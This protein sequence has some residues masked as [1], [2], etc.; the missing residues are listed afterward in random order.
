MI[1]RFLWAPLALALAMLPAFGSASTNE[2]KIGFQPYTAYAPVLVAKEKGYVEKA[3]QAAGAGNVT[4]KWVQFLT[5]PQTN[6]AL[7]SGDIDMIAGEGDMP[8]MLAKASGLDI[9]VVGLVCPAASEEALVV[10]SDSPVHSVKEL[11]GLKVA[12]VHGG[13]AYA[14]LVLALKQAGLSVD[15]VQLVNLA[16]GEM[17]VALEN[18][19]VDA[20]T[21]FEPLLTRG[22]AGGNVRVLRDGVGLTSNL[23]LFAVSSAFAK[24]NP[25]VLKAILKAVRQGADDLRAHPKEWATNLAPVIGL[26]PSENAHAMLHHD[27][28]PN[29]TAANIAEMKSDLQFMVDN[30]FAR[31]SFDVNSFVDMSYQP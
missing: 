3:L 27:W 12:S 2:V 14:F 21:L 11:K 6:Q 8:L 23:Q 28:N 31:T 26:T 5:G 25:V 7:A 17:I 20:A 19:S 18:K 24:Q 16:P 10:R 4:V 22:E 9:K 15:D 29:L 30:G 13:N 1:R